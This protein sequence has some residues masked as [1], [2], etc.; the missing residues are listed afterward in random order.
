[1]RAPR[2]RIGVEV[3]SLQQLPQAAL[4]ADV[5]QRQHIQPVCAQ[6][7]PVG[8]LHALH[9]A[10]GEHARAAGVPDHVRHQHGGRG[11]EAREALAVTPLRH[12]VHL[13]EDAQRKGVH[14]PRGAGGQAGQVL[15][16]QR[17]GAADEEHVHLQAAADAGALHFHR[18]GMPALRQL[19]AVD[20]AERGGGDGAR[21][22]PAEE[23]LHRRA[24]L[25]L[26]QRERLGV[27]EAGE[28]VLQLL[29]GIVWSDEREKTLWRGA[30]APKAPPNKR[31][32]ASRGVWRAP[33]R[34]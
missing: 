4:D 32:V 1:M 33:G 3:S 30:A 21:G 34:L 24:Q 29:Q 16:Q 14:S 6:R 19:G 22:D 12:V 8:Q 18:H 11:V 20:L 28:A 23:A 2:V 25:R 13:L 9:P 5:D 10:G 27:G 15:V 31:R 7:R 17:G 26:D